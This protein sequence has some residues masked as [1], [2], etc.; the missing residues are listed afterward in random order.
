ME[1]TL[2][3]SR[4]QALDKIKNSE[5]GFGV[6]DVRVPSEFTKDPDPFGKLGIHP[7]F[8]HFPWTDFLDEK[9]D[10]APKTRYKLEALGLKP[11]DTIAVIDERG[12]GA[13]D[14]VLRLRELGYANAK[15]WAG[16]Y[17]ELRGMSSPSKST[18]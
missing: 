10:L 4:A 5:A 15:L 8:E 7:R 11:T 16:G 9:G 2:Q 14:A 3:I 13:A 6:L 1:E 18:K 12:V 17:R